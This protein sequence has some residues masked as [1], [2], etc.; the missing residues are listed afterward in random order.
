VPLPGADKGGTWVRMGDKEY[1]VAPLNFKALREMSESIGVLQ[2]VQSGTMPTAAQ[3]GVLVQ[4]AHAALKRNYPIITEDEVA[5]GLDFSNFGNVLG[6]VMG[7]SAINKKELA[8][9]E[10]PP[11]P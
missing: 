3:M 5:D 4:L 1:K 9:G 11:N 6:A 2:N 7:A 8:P 10:I